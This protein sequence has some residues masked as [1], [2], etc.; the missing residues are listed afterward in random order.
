LGKGTRP[1]D[2]YHKICVHLVFDVKHDGRHKS[3]LVADGHLTE[4]PLDSVYSGVVSLRGIRLL[5]FLAELN[6]LDLWTTDIGNAYLEAE[7]QE[8]VYIITGPEFGELEGHTLIIFKALYG[9]RTSGLCWHERFADCLRDMGFTPCKA[10]PDIWMRQNGNI[11]KY[12]GVYVDDVA[13]AT[14]DPKAITDLLQDKYQFKLKG[15]GPISFHLGCNFVWD[16][17]GTICMSPQKYIKNLLGTYKCIFSSKPRQ[18]VTSPLEK[19]D[20][21]ELDMS[22]ELDA[23][24]IKNYQSLIGALQWSVL[25]GR[26]NITTAIMM[27]SG[28][29]VTP[30]KGHL[31]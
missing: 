19:A 7:T 9:L 14:K 11:Y 24:G 25:L 13:A 31:E 20:H 2:G 21:P 15:T 4:I 8:K 30:R 18:N 6:D 5:V 1:P 10:E 28:F 17:D 23:D 16:N 22:D 27:M 26:I 12:I 3:R 29:Q